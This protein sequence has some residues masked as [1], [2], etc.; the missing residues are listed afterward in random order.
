[1]I[2]LLMVASCTDG[3]GSNPGVASVEDTTSVV[4]IKESSPENI[5]DPTD[6]QIV[7]DFA[8]CVRQHG[9]TIPDPEINSDLS[10]IHI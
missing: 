7:T 4:A 10:L 2:L 8:S 3:P 6:E 5:I 9:I 1:M